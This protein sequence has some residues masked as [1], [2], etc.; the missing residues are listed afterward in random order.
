MAAEGKEDGPFVSG[1]F[2]PGLE[3]EILGPTEAVIANAAYRAGA[4]GM[5]LAAVKDVQGERAAWKKSTEYGQG[6][7]TEE[8][9]KQRMELRR[10]RHTAADDALEN[11]ERRIAA[12]PLYAAA[13]KEDAR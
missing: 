7:D 3:C 2:V 12:L 10:A 13:G 8:E 11:T 9:A 1:G 6:G 4:E 5:R